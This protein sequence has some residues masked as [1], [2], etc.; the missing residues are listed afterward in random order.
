LSYRHLLKMLVAPVHNQQPGHQQLHKQ[1][2][3]SLAKCIAA[4]TQQVPNEAVPVATEFLNEIRRSDA[5]MVFYLLT[6][7]EIGRHL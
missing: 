4:L 7:G 3:H 1:A 5:H 6:I 2:F